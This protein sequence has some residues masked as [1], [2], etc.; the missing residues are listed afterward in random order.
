M[1]RDDARGDR[2]ADDRRG[3]AIV[4]QTIAEVVGAEAYAQIET[5]L[6][7]ALAGERVTYEY[8]RTRANG[9]RVFARSTV[10]PEKR[11]EEVV[12]FFVLSF[13]I[14]EQRAQQEALIQAQKMEAASRT[15]S[16]IC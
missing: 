12:G 13:D 10:V 9:K 8:H 3:G 1:V 7:R 6:E 4:G 11:G 15:T 16:T 14:T 5:H 2:R